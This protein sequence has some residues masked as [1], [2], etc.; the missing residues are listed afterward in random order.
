MSDKTVAQL[1]RLEA[2]SLRKQ[3]SE[4]IDDLKVVGTC[5]AV[6]MEKAASCGDEESLFAAESTGRVFLLL[7]LAA[8]DDLPQE[9]SR[10]LAEIE[11]QLS[12][13]QAQHRALARLS[14]RPTP[15][16]VKAFREQIAT[17]HGLKA[18]EIAARSLLRKEVGDQTKGTFIKPFVASTLA[19]ASIGALAGGRVGAVHG[20]ALGG[21]GGLILGSGN[22][23]RANANETTAVPLYANRPEALTAYQSGV[24]SAMGR[25]SDHFVKERMLDHAMS[26]EENL[27]PEDE[28]Q[29]YRDILSFD[30]RAEEIQLTP[31]ELSTIKATA[32]KIHYAK[33][34]PEMAHRLDSA[35]NPHPHQN[36]LAE[37]AVKGGLAGYAI[38]KLTKRP[39][40]IAGATAGAAGQW[41]LD[42]LASKKGGSFHQDQ[43]LVAKYR[44]HP[45]MLTTGVAGKLIA[46][47]STA[48]VL[49]EMASASPAQSALLKQAALVL[50][51]KVINGEISGELAQ[52]CL[53]E[54]S[55]RSHG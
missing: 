20:A 35:Y 6:L 40:V 16:E 44:N 21:L 42:Q 45:A 10:Q 49:P 8:Y 7:K 23:I 4:Q 39:A 31:A 11:D 9:H 38:R 50:G 46:N 15:E 26:P 22:A 29:M 19:G 5:A 37:G 53:Q 13:I 47:R 24:S 55:R 1:L 41:A 14:F 27:H 33:A 48:S 25:L 3:A 52:A 32:A 2:E 51:E 34:A 54:V 43:L 30:K 18:Q 36:S 28:A 12:A 17:V